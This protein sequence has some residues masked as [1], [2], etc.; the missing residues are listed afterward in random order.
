[1]AETKTCQNCK[2]WYKYKPDPDH[3]LE[4]DICVKIKVYGFEPYAFSNRRAITEPDFGCT[5]FEP[6]G[7]LK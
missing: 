5:K 1:M 7:D 3:K 2:F 4:V 6:Q